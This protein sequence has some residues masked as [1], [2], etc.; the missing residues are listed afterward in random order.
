MSTLISGIGGYHP[1]AASTNGSN[2]VFGNPPKT[3]TIE[4]AKTRIA[5]GDDIRR[6]VIQDTAENITDGFADLKGWAGDKI[7]KGI[8]VSDNADVNIRVEDLEGTRS[9]VSTVLKRLE[10][11]TVKVA[12][13]ASE[14]QD[15]LDNLKLYQRRLD[16]MAV[17]RDLDGN[18]ATAGDQESPVLSLTTSEYKAARKVL[19]KLE[20]ALVEVTLSG[21]YADYQLKAGKNGAI[22]A[23]G[24][25]KFTGTA[26]FL[27][28][29]DGQRVV[30]TS[31]DARI[32][33]L[34]EVGKR[35]MW[36]TAAQTTNKLFV[37][38]SAEN[39]DLA[40]TQILK[41]GVV[42]L[43]ESLDSADPIELTFGFH[44]D[45]TS[46]PVNDKKF[47]VALDEAQKAVVR[48]AFS[49]LGSL[50]NVTFTEETLDAD[51]SFQFGTNEQDSSAAYAYMPQA[52]GKATQIM[53][54]NNVGTN[55]FSAILS[56]D[57]VADDANDAET[58]GYQIKDADIDTLR[59]SY[60]WLTLVHEIGHAL[61][62]K[63]PGN[64]NAGGGGASQP[65]LPK[66]M[67]SR[68]WTVMSY[69]SAPAATG[70]SG[71]GAAT[72]Q[73]PQTMMVY[74]IAA[75]QFLYGKSEDDTA[76][77]DFQTTTFTNT[78]NGFQ[79]VWSADPAGITFDLSAR[80]NQV[81]V[82]MRPGTFSS[83]ARFNDS[84]LAFGSQYGTVKTGSADDVIFAG[85]YTAAINGG[86]G[87]DTVYLA[88]KAS[89]YQLSADANGLATTNPGSV[90]RTVGSESVSITLTNI[91]K[92]KFY[93]DTRVSALHG[94]DRF[95]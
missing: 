73:N 72:S 16:G 56:G 9:E 86:G 77:D 32:D 64:Y 19:G 48:D 79:T 11:A 74:D 28:F 18:T 38:S 80:T 57:D 94:I 45:N 31:G 75:L 25:D 42:A 30:A 63:H 90:T 39:T 61:G 2:Q 83:V 71:I 41:P 89:D 5:G 27:K 13:V 70:T 17:V 88:G 62:L 54:A 91:E 6:M 29:D 58:L 93:D 52:T 21:N 78:W 37:N 66:I 40:D 47:F 1:A 36:S 34:L 43:D 14:I 67:D 50:I 76:L 55:N 15:G 59:K 8:K 23:R 84:G 46:V 69:S 35:N 68:Q 82:D 49:Y 95:A 7:L 20:G 44:A 3:Y 92:I 65:Y 10:K 24:A 85:L 87:S 22:V 81:I 53:L 12:D 33:A 51:T 4:Q 60:G 26:N